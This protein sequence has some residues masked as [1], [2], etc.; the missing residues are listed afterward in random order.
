MTLSRFYNENTRRLVPYTAGEQPQNM[1]FIKLNTNENPYPPSPL[2]MERIKNFDPERLR[3]Y[4]NSD[5]AIVKK[6]VSE[7]YMIPEDTVF[8]GNV[9]TRYWPL[10]SRPFLTAAAK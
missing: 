1:N 5:G 9:L 8:A 7:F 4:P 3:L 10:F 2:V 6:A